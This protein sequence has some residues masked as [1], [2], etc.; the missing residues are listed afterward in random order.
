[1]ET[2]CHEERNA[3]ICLTINC[4]SQ[5]LFFL[6]NLNILLYDEVVILMVENHNRM[7]LSKFTRSFKRISKFDV[8]IF[9][10]PLN[11]DMIFYIDNVLV[12]SLFRYIF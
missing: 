8:F 10:S 5:M 3:S 9:S 12:L 1:M 4:L 7:I 11:F 6:L 2:L